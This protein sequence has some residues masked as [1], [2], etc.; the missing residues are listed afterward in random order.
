MKKIAFILLTPGHKDGTEITEAVSARLALSELNARVSYFSFNE[1]FA[2]RNALVESQR[3]SRGESLAIDQLNPDQ[4]DALVIPGGSG[5][6]KNLSSW[7]IDQENFKIH[8]ALHEVILKFHQQSKPIGAICI[9]PFLVGN[10]LKKLFSS[11][12]FLL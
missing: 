10:I 9:A 11:K 12:H 7:A 6:L 4:F 2:D 8:P 5:V 1:N 3:L